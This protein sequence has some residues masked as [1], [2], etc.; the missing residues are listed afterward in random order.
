MKK[1]EMVTRIDPYAIYSAE[2]VE[3]LLKGLASLPTLR[4]FGLRG[5]ADGYYGQNIHDA[6]VS[7]LSHRGKVV[8]ERETNETLECG[9][10]RGGLEV[11]PAQDQ[12]NPLESSR[13]RFLRRTA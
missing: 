6:L 7:W 5:L 4:R 11:H 12:S 10:S 9:S 8:S 3:A 13:Q 2:E 1:G